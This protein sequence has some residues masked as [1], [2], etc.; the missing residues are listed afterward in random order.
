[1]PQNL[2]PAGRSVFGAALMLAL[3]APGTV[4]AQKRYAAI[5][6]YVTDTNGVAVPG[7]EVAILG[8][9]AHRIKTDSTGGFRFVSVGPGEQVLM[10]RRMGFIARSFVVELPERETTQL[11]LEL[12][13]LAV[14][15]PD[16]VVNVAPSPSR[17][18]EMRRRQEAG[19]G[20]YITRREIELRKPRR[21]TD[22]LRLQLGLEVSDQM[23]QAEI[24]STRGPIMNLAGPSPTLEGQLGRLS[25]ESSTNQENAVFRALAATMGQE[26]LKC[27]LPVILD[28]QLMSEGFSIDDILPSEIET[29]EIYRGIASVP[30]QYARQET[31]CGV[32]IVWTREGELKRR[33]PSRR[34]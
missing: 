5:T 14:V 22:L 28:S 16:V 31:R 8:S 7:V 20:T 33:A 1:M 13:P 4:D 11:V 2:P 10:A 30:T 29:I 9:A 12:E 6:G 3:L 21:T 25:D 34:N 26:M 15:M 17:F 19:Y 27:R 23:G 18:D 24:L 32:V